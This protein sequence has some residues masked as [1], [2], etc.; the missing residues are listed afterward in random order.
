M[1]I[2][3]IWPMGAALILAIA[4]A[5]V[6]SSPGPTSVLT[7]AAT[8]TTTPSPSKEWSLENIEVDGSTVTVL[9]QVFAGIDVQVTLDGR[10]P[11]QVKTAVP[12]LGFVFEE[13]PPGS[14]T[15]GVS[16]VLGFEQTAEVV[17]PAP[18]IP[19]WLTDL[20]Q[21]LESEPVASPPASITQYEFKGQT[22]YF[23]PQRCCD[24]FSN[25]YDADGNMIGHP[26]GGFAGQGDGRVPDFFE[27]RN[28]QRVIWQDRRTRLIEKAAGVNGGDW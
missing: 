23:L 18:G 19:G 1:K 2:W 27:E 24:I 15:I 8:P 11:D 22:V 20:V 17:V 7:P 10:D 16:D 28:N 3:M 6:N 25:L 4:A 14:H 9:L 26:D 12:D 13:V 21:R 5:C